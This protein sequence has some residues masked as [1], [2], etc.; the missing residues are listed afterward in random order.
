MI[1]ILVWLGICEACQK[2][3]W[4]VVLFLVPLANIILPWYLALSKIEGEAQEEKS[5]EDKA[6]GQNKDKSL[7]DISQDVSDRIIPPSDPNQSSRF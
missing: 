2:P 5:P 3:K 4:L 7:E 1:I 6:L